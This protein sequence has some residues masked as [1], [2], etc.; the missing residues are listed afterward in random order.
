MLATGARPGELIGLSMADI[1]ITGEILVADLTD[2]KNAHRGLSR[3][4]FFGP[5]SQLILRRR[6]SIG[7]LFPVKKPVAFSKVVKRACLAAKIPPF[8]P[9]ALRHT[10]ATALRD[11]IGIESA[12][13][14]LGHAQPSMTA[15]YSSKMDVL[16]IEAA[17][18]CG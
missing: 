9:Y 4:L 15:R 17:K 14:T 16:A 7:P 2:H 13:A 6:P 3:K 5:Q 12:Q 10:K 18:A 11:A 1:D 8:V